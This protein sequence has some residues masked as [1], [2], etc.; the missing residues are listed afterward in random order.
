MTKNMFDT[1]QERSAR[2]RSKQI[3]KTAE[4]CSLKKSSKN[5]KTIT[6][7]YFNLMNLKQ[8]KVNENEELVFLSSASSWRHKN[9]KRVATIGQQQLSIVLPKRDLKV[10][11][12]TLAMI[13]TSSELVISKNN[14]LYLINP[15]QC[16]TST[17]TLNMFPMPN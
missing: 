10:K 7:S 12:C 15:K 13:T 8:W 16:T 6:N 9:L 3:T 4:R 5:R 1:K 2:Q 14:S 11:I 17:M